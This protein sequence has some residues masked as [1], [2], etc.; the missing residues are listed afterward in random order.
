MKIGSRVKATNYINRRSTIVDIT[1]NS[2]GTTIYWL[3]DGGGF[4]E[5]E[6]EPC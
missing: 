5:G 4:S 1:I 2:L 6:L 3:A